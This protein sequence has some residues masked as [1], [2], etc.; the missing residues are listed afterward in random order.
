MCEINYVF[1]ISNKLIRKKLIE[2][3]GARFKTKLKLAED[4]DF[5][6]QLYGF[7]KNA[8]FSDINSFYYL[9]TATNYQNNQKVDYYSQITVHLDIRAWF[10]KNGHYSKYKRILD[11][12]VVEYVYYSL[13]YAREYSEDIDK[14]FHQIVNNTVITGCIDLDEF[15]GFQKAVLS[16]V[17]NDNS[18]KLKLLLNGRYLIREIY[19]RMK[20]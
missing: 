5:Y 1:F 15:S 13:F 19:R 12:K 10:I 20:K 4:L 18:F 2:E 6:A 16:A 17:K 3:S 14:V 8:Y 9:Q 11:K 7:V